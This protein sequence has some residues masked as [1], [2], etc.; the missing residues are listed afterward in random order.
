M[1]KTMKPADSIIDPDREAVLR[2][3]ERATKAG[4]LYEVVLGFGFYSALGN[5]PEEAA[6]SALYD[7]D[8]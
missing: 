5:E 4:M 8:V 3:I 7:W 2:M 6:R 1:N